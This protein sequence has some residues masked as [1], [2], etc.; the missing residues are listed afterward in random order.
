MVDSLSTDATVDILRR[1]PKVKVLTRPFDSLAQQWNFGLSYVETPWV[2]SLDADYQVSKIL[3][4]EFRQLEP[5]ENID[6]YFVPLRYCV[7]GKPLRGTLLPPRQVLFRRDNSYYINDGHRQLLQIQNKTGNLSGHLDHDDRK[8][9]GHWLWAQNRYM[10]LEV[11]KLT[12]TPND[13]LSLSDKIRKTKVLAPGIIFLYC[14]ILKGGIFD[15]WRGLYYASQRT[16]AELLLAIHLVE[17]D[18][19]QKQQPEQT[20]QNQPQKQQTVNTTS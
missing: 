12:T 17:N 1:Y 20:L 4:E 3:I 14:L 18:F 11:N 13:Q 6:S 19:R 9:L 2:L 5:S 10:V 16:L 15:G 7:F 8:S